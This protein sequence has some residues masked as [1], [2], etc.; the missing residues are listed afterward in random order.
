MAQNAGAFA[1]LASEPQALSFFAQN[2]GAFARLG[3]DAN[4]HNLVGM[5]AFATAAQ[6]SQ[7]ANAVNSGN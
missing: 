7:F 6:S 5:S 2:M 4:F 3:Q 1:R